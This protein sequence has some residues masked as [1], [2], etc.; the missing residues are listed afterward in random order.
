MHC[1]THTRSQK[2]NKAHPSA[3]LRNAAQR[4][5]QLDGCLFSHCHNK[6]SKKQLEAPSY[7]NNSMI[8]QLCTCRVSQPCAVGLMVSVPPLQSLLVSSNLN[9][10]AWH[11]KTMTCCDLATGL[12][13]SHK[14]SRYWEQRASLL[15]ARMLLGAPGLTTRNNKATFLARS[16]ATKG[17]TTVRQKDSG[18]PVCPDAHFTST[19]TTFQQL[20]QCWPSQSSRAN[21]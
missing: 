16:P 9:Q 1:Q 18:A 13:Q 19:N 14:L 21:I 4:N 6:S 11:G 5:T 7:P 10:Q 2:H 15:G 8:M 12:K 20:Q 17:I 3:T